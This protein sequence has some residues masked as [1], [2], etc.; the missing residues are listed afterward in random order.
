MF[1]CVESTGR[2]RMSKFA[3]CFALLVLVLGLNQILA[4]L[5]ENR[6]GDVYE[7]LHVMQV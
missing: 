6:A 1:Y 3:A 4:D 2:E 5:N 7:A